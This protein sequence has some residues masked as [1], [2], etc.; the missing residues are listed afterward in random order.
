VILENDQ[1][2]DQLET[3]KRE[4]LRIV[5]ENRDHADVV[6]ANKGSDGD[7]DEAGVASRDE[8]MELK[9]RA[10]LLTEENQALF[11]QIS[12]FRAHYDEFNKAH[13]TKV[14]EANKKI[15]QFNK[16]T[17]D[18]QSV[19]LQRDNLNKTN[20]FLDKKLSETS[21]K[22]GAAEEGR[23]HDQSELMKTKEQ[24]TLVTREYE[25]YRDLAEKLEFRQTDELTNLN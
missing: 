20:Q 18:L 3:T 24:L 7:N 11:Q 12:V 5:E 2:R 21:L 1:L 9:N 25:F 17:N 8:I 4:L 22:L 10:H 23:R 16:L 6:R 14:T 13:E 19:I 15:A